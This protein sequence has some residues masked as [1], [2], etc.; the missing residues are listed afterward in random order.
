MSVTRKTLDFYTP[1]QGFSAIAFFFKM[2]T[3][4]LAL[5]HPNCLFVNRIHLCFYWNNL[6]IVRGSSSNEPAVHAS[7][8]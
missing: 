1:D 5:A 4:V 2:Y 7:I 6:S 3:T 8:A